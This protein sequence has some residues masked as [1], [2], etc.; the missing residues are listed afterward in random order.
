MEGPVL[1]DSPDTAEGPLLSRVRSV[2]AIENQKGRR[3][4]RDVLDK[5]LTALDR[6][7]CGP[8]GRPSVLAEGHHRV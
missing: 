8:F 7:P 4:R 2:A 3:G 6:A 1:G 5:K